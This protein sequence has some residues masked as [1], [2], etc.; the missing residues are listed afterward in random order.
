M[1][2]TEWRLALVAG[3]LVC[4]VAVLWLRG[5]LRAR[6]RRARLAKP[7]PPEW[8][9]LLA[10]RVPLYRRMP[11]ELRRRMEPATRA[12]LEHVRFVGCQGLEVTDEMR[13]VV[14]FQA[15]LL[16]VQ[17]DPG[18][19]ESLH[20]VLLYPD[21][22]VVEEAEE[23]EAGVVTEGTRVLSGQAFDTDRIVLSWRDVLDGGSAGE[24]AYNVVLHEFAHWLD[25]SVGSALSD[26][27]TRLAP[28]ARWHAVFEREYDTLCE[29]IERGEPTLIDPYGAEHPAEFLAVATETFFEQPRRMARHHPGLYA[30]L[31]ELYGLDPARW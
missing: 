1:S 17:R 19:Y 14:A 10:R 28:L 13:L 8:R 23:D 4:I 22:F 11:D 31:R 25:H 2:E 5:A 26:A 3:A 20:S 18:A 6:R 16:V 24:D 15:S 27:S 9:A 21:E 7:F 12:F 29:A 30:E